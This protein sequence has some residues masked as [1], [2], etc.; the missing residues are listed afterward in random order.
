LLKYEKAWP[1]TYL[2]AFGVCAS[3]IELLGRCLTGNT[4][5][6]G[7]VQDL[8]VGFEWLKSSSLKAGAPLSAIAVTSYTQYDVD[9]LETL[10]HFTSH[11]QATKKPSRAL[12]VDIELLAAFPWLIGNAMERYW[13]ELLNSPTYCENLAKANIIPL[14]S[15]PVKKMWEFFDRRGTSAGTPFYQFDWKIRQV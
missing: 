8:R 6:S 1:V 13:H 10:R 4:G 5:T 15:G 11:G 7:C 9:L 2:P 3:G 14:R 12:A